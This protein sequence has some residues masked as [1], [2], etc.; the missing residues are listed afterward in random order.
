VTLRAIGVEEFRSLYRGITRSFDHL[1]MRDSYGTA[2]EIPQI[3]RW[4]AGE[5][6][7]L[8]WLDEWRG[9]MGRFRD[10]GKRCRRAKVVS[11]PLSE[12]QRWNH[13]VLGPIV[14]AGEQIRWVDRRTVSCLALPPSDFYLLDEKT[15]MFLHFTGDGQANGYTVT[16]DSD[17][18]DL[19]RTSFQAVWGLSI[20]HDEFQPESR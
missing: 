4:R 9:L 16:E 12:Y 8:G 2:V 11:L 7:D 5:P 19:C 1:E 15:A 3:A 20:P 13:S 10:Q 14:A 6:D 17:V 18:V